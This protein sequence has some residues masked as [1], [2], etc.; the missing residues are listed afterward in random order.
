M[1]FAA[2]GVLQIHDDWMVVGSVNNIC[3]GIDWIQSDVRDRTAI[4]HNFVPFILG[5]VL[6]L[7]DKDCCA[8]C[9]RNLAPPSNKSCFS[10][11]SLLE[12]R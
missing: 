10:N 1:N 8:T 12:E 6:L 9:K 2:S 5:K 3:Q 7:K 4:F 11:R